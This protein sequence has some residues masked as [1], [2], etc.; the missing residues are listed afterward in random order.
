MDQ[1]RTRAAIL[2]GAAL[3]FAADTRP[4]VPIRDAR[5]LAAG[6]PVERVNELPPECYRP[7]VQ[8]V[9]R[10]SAEIGRIAFRAPLLLGGEAARVGL[11]CSS[12]HRNGRDNPAFHFPGISG[13]PGT[14]DV[15]TS[16][17]SSHRGDGTFNPKPIP[18]LAGNPAK[19]IVSRDASKPDLEKF[20][21]G[22]I[23]QEF[24]G[25]EPPRKVLDGITAYVRAISAGNC[26]SEPVR[27]T[28]P[29]VLAEAERALEL[30]RDEPDPA[31][32]RLLIGAARS[33]LGR[34]DQRFQVAEVTADRA[35]LVEA[36]SQLQK[37]QDGLGTPGERKLWHGWDRSWPKIK[38]RIVSDA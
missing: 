31:T 19:R 16:I 15:T 38:A 23:T 7:P 12:C 13:A 18:D 8:R 30:A 14:A 32:A 6:V 10:R 11:S 5:W 4:P 2:I 33:N 9:E 26:G 28:A 29:Y 34:V 36:D 27:L 22:L 35:L 37:L 20:V 3:L 24:D 21:H 17:L 25:P 1:G